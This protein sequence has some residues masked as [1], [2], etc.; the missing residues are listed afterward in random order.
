MDVL[1]L[2]S[3][4]EGYEH[5]WAEAGTKPDHQGPGDTEREGTVTD[6][7]IAEGPALL[8]TYFEIIIALTE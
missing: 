8:V 3:E 6:R 5:M 7:D 4:I 1:W 2:K